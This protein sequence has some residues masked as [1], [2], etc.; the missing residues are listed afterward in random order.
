MN[1]SG[2]KRGLAASAVA[3]L[4]VA[5]LPLLASSASA[6]SGDSLSVGNVGPV[7]NANAAGGSVIIK[8][9]SATIDP[10][11]VGVT[12]ADFSG[13]PNLIA[14]SPDLASP[15]FDVD[16]ISF[17]LLDGDSVTA[18]IQKF[19]DGFY[20]Y[21][22]VTAVTLGTAT[23]ATFGL[24]E[25]ADASGAVNASDP[26]TVV[27]ITPTG[28]PASVDVS[29]AS[30]TTATTVQSPDYTVTVKDAAG[31]VTQV[32][33][34]ESFA[35]TSPQDAVATGTLD[36]TTLN[37][38]VATFT[39]TAPTA[40][41]KTLNVAG[42]GGIAATVADSATLNVIAQA[43][44]VE[45]EF[46]IATGADTW[47]SSSTFGGAGT[48]IRVDQ[49]TVTFNF[50]SKDGA[51][52]DSIPDDANKVV[53]LTLNS[54]TL[55]FDG[56]TAPQT[57]AVVLDADGKGSLTVSPNG[58][59][60]GSAFTFAAPGSAIASTTVTFARAAAS[61]VSSD[62]AVYV[63][64]IGSPTDVTVTVK[65]QFGNPIGA[66]AQVSI[67]RNP[68]AP[69][70]ANAGTTSR[71]TVDATGKATISLPDAGTTAGSE[72]LDVNLYDD[73]FDP[74]ATT[75]VGVARI[76]YTVD[77]LGADY[78]VTGATSDPAATV[79]SPVYDA[80]ATPGTDAV[81]VGI[82]GGTFDAPAKVSVDNGALILSG[83]DTTLDKGVASKTITLNGA[84]AGSVD[85]IG[86][87]TGVVTVTIESAGRTKTV[88]LT[89]K[90][91]AVG[92]A[93][94]A[95]ARNVELAGPEK[96]N[97]GGVATFTATVT[98]AFGNPVEG[99][100]VNE[101]SFQV[102]GPANLQS[103]DAATNGAGELQ[104]NVILTDNANSSVSV[105][106]TGV[107]SVA[108]QFGKAVNTF[109]VANDAPGLSASDNTDTVTVTNVVNI[110]ELQAAVD[111][112]QEKVDN[113]QDA[114]DTA[115]GNLRIA[116]AERAVARQDVRE[117]KRDLRQAKRHHK[118]VKAARKALR[119]ARGELR[120]ANAKVEV[121]QA[122]VNRAIERLE[123][124][125][126]E[127]AAAQQA[128]ADAQS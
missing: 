47:S 31:N 113:A 35:V 119:Q 14:G 9:N 75:T 8:S 125:Q 95:T 52:A 40:G 100:S 70:T 11:K 87:K 84:G 91:P 27:E 19:A 110:A 34:G 71:V 64:K 10:A 54:G 115:R 121:A 39:A 68:V 3:A 1:S 102:S 127:L 56:K 53:L 21:D 124:A 72:T 12:P 36:D 59:V 118:G 26:K 126:A 81:T 17:T 29:P 37:D 18:G 94:T 23:K 5:G 83:G 86:T 28:A 66:P 92:A 128:L 51:D 57:Y 55:K 63:T 24:V 78:S 97:A 76:D 89:I 116:K 114:L 2:I 120:I 6:T 43:T 7:R 96:A 15:A 108:T 45:N 69:R 46:D 32:K 25:D 16:L 85:V 38:G 104:A 112:A 79:V 65:D 33:A 48:Q 123:A 4:A 73:Q 88:K 77:G 41:T 90:Q 49:S 109:A 44:I 30:Q 42:A 62:A 99:V 67:T 80:T 74:A 82:T 22:A 106:V 20:H 93:L 117:A 103:T 122:I 107:P 58:I 101:L 13:T 50:V 111:A 60:D 98:D 105:K 61:A